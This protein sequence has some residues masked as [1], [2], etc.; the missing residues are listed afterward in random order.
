MADTLSN[1]R[2]LRDISRS[3]FAPRHSERIAAARAVAERAA[4]RNTLVWAGSGVQLYGGLTRV[5]AGG[6]ARRDFTTDDFRSAGQAMD[7]NVYT[8]NLLGRANV[9]VYP[10][11]ARH[12]AN[13][14]FAAKW[15]RCPSESTEDWKPSMW[16]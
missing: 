10:L 7:D 4:R 14:S 6:G 1:G 5:A 2:V 15:P 3:E 12:G 16:P 8:F 13:T 9:A 11:D